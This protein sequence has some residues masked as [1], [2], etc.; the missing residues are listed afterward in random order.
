MQR[1][2]KTPS[3]T[4]ESLLI[5]RGKIVDSP[6]FE[7]RKLFHKSYKYD[8]REKSICFEKTST[9]ILCLIL[10]CKWAGLFELCDRRKRI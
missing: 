7:S 4:P 1:Y 9:S 10:I 6:F 3:P 5:K 8:D 2:D